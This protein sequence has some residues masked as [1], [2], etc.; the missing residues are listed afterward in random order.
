MLCLNKK[1][2]KF[3]SYYG[4]KNIATNIFTDKCIFLKRNINFHQVLLAYHVLKRGITIHVFVYLGQNVF[5]YTINCLE[6]I[7]LYNKCF[8]ASN[9]GS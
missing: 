4:N 1:N 5:H 2:P 8:E 7:F 6:S 9:Q 3:K